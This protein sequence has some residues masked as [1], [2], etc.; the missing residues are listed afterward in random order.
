MNII[1]QRFHSLRRG[2]IPFAAAALLTGGINAHAVVVTTLAGDFTFGPSPLDYTQAASLAAFNGPGTLL[3]VRIELSGS[4]D[5]ILTAT[6][7]STAGQVLWMTEDASFSITGL[8]FAGLTTSV[9]TYSVPGFALAANTSQVFNHSAAAPLV[10]VDLSA[11]FELAAYDMS[12]GAPANLAF[13]FSAEEFFDFRKSGSGLTAGSEATAGGN[14]RVYYTYDVLPP[15]PTPVPEVSTAVSAAA[16]ALIGGVFM[17][18][19]RRK[20]STVTT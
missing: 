17:I 14:V 11:A 2:L 10:S 19:N 9:P 16:F 20:Q 4:A 5:F 13:L 3:G 1:S 18:R 6:A 15:P 8:P 12:L 7:K